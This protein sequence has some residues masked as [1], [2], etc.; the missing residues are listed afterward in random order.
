LNVIKGKH[1]FNRSGLAA[2]S[3]LNLS[4][5]VK[6]F[7]ELEREQRIYLDNEPKFRSNEYIWPCDP[8]HTW[9]RIWEY[10]YVYHNIKAWRQDLAKDCMPSVVDVGSGV[11]FFP[12][13]VAKLGCE[14]ICTDIDPV[15]MEDLSRACNH[16]VHSPGTVDFRLVENSLLPFDN[17]ECD[18]VY[19]ISVLEHITDFEKTI[20]EMARI[21]KPN[22]LCLITC[23]INLNPM[24]KIQFD[25][26][27]YM[28]FT[29]IIDKFFVLV[30]P[31]YTI[32]PLNILTSYN[33]PYPLKGLPSG[34][35]GI[36]W[37]LIKQ[38]VLKPIMGQKPGS[39]RTLNLA[40][41]GL[42]M[43]KKT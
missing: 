5:Y 25:K 9:S 30:L 33:S 16:I 4:E 12:F 23:D 41:L 35:G 14:V 42:A 17:E 27:R 29:T 32:H 40:I 18:A 31:E 26:E 38:K 37:R 2:L 39:L 1:V 24:E 28:Y 6:I 22:G 36:A 21:L 19:C 34:F 10:P 8:L 13:S 11:T 3:D 20:A 7:S 15:C 43:K